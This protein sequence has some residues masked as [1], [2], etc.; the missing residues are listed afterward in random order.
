MPRKTRC[1]QERDEAWYHLHNRGA[2]GGKLFRE[3]ED[4]RVFRGIARS[5]QVEMFPRI[6]I[7]TYCY[8]STHYHYT[9]KQQSRGDAARFMQKVMI[10]YASYYRK[11]YDYHGAL[12]E[13]VLQG[14]L[15]R[16]LRD[17]KTV[18]RYIL[19]NPKKAGLKMWPYVGRGHNPKSNWLR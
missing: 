4:Y 11:K 9:I 19:D 12:C 13:S 3:D 5:V 7:S 2:A 1:R 15:L 17:L 14:R 8:L 6:K 18:E 16:G 10:I